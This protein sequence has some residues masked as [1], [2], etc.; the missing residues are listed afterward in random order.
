MLRERPNDVLDF[1]SLYPNIMMT[2]NLCYSTLITESDLQNLSSQYYE[3]TPTGDK[4]VLPHLQIGLLPLILK[5]LLDARR[6]VKEEILK[7]EDPW[8]KMIFDG[9]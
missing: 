3:V 8:E 7:C 1:A 9:R 6:W 2:H 4:F 5:E